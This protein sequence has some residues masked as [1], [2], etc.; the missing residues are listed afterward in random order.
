MRFTFL[1]KSLTGKWGLGLGTVFIIFI[2]MK[3]QGWMP[4]PTFFIAALGLTGF[5]LSILAVFRN[6]DKAILNMIPLLAG[7]IIIIW[8]TAELLFPH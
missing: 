6:R 8:F 4:L 5:V 2:C 7:L 3:I 1:P